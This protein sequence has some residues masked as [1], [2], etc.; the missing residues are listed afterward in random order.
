[1]PARSSQQ[2]ITAITK[3]EGQTRRIFVS[4]MNILEIDRYFSTIIKLTMIITGIRMSK[5]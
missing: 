1:V 3:A 5:F 4:K 2:N